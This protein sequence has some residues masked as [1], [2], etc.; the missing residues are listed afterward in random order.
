MASFWKAVTLSK[1]KVL[2]KNSLLRVSLF[3]MSSRNNFGAFKVK[4]EN[5]LDIHFS[6]LN[7]CNER[8]PACIHFEVMFFLIVRGISTFPSLRGEESYVTAQS[9]NVSLPYASNE[10]PPSSYTKPL[11]WLLAAKHNTIE[12]YTIYTTYYHTHTHTARRMAA[13]VHVTLWRS[14]RV[15]ARFE[16]HYWAAVWRKAQVIPA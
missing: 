11:Y 8:L 16:W 10:Y 4:L 13:G 7:E 3:T 15:A 14:W 12:N 9:F 5:Y 1:S 6:C 2:V